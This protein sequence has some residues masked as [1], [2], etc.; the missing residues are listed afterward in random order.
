LP[1][2]LFSNN[3]ISELSNFLKE[4]SNNLYYLEL[5]STFDPS[6]EICGNGI[7]DNNN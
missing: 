3:N 2:A 7:D 4:T 6:E 5:G 1:A